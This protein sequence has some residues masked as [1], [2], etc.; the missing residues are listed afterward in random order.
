MDSIN[1]FSCFTVTASRR[2]CLKLY[3]SLPIQSHFTLALLSCGSVGIESYM[4]SLFVS[5]KV[6]PENRTVV[7]IAVNVCMTEN[8]C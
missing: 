1:V 4:F 7:C 2:S 3:H 8:E 6:T 5:I